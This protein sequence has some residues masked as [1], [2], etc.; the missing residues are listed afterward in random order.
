MTTVTRWTERAVRGI[1]T[2]AAVFVATVPV[3]AQ[4]ASDPGGAGTAVVTDRSAMP[5]PFG[6]GEDM[7]YKVKLGVVP[8]GEG[9]MTVQG[10]D[11]IRGFPSYRLR[12]GME[13]SALLGTLQ[14]N[15]T[16]ESWLDTGMLVSR[17]FIRD[18]DQPGYQSRREFEI[19]PEE[20]R[21]ERT[22]AEK[23]GKGPL[24]ALD[25]ISFLYFIRTLPLEV[26]DTYEFNRYFKDDGNPV[27]VRV[28]RRERVEVPAGVFDA[29]VVQPVIQTDGLFSEGGEAE[30]FF[31]DDEDRHLIYLRSKLPLVGSLSLHLESIQEGTPV[32]PDAR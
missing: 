8:V 14:L 23:E 11:T 27:V 30:V 26:G 7:R 25:E 10:I 18:V 1:A 9:R 4:D 21:W 16:Y 31:T 17:R 29:V 24:L 5:A 12:V 2:A 28:L 3:A 13:A 32:H 20:G 19:Y 6:P 22:D 15:D